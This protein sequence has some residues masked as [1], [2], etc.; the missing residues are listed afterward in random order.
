MAGLVADRA[1]LK[2]SEGTAPSTLHIP[3]TKRG[4]AAQRAIATVVDNVPMVNISS[5]G[6]CKS[7]ANP[8]VAAATSA[9]GGALTPQ[10]C[11]PVIPAP[12]SRGASL[13]TLQGVAV[14]TKDSTCSCAWAG[15]IEVTDPSSDVEVT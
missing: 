9:Q 3:P 7:L 2:C 1:K 6:M 5:F 14:V 13:V 10:P 8:Q 11:V 4:D 15:T 12:W